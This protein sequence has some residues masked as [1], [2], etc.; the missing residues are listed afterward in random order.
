M[1]TAVKP[2]LTIKRR[3]KVAPEKVFAAW[4]DPQK[5]M[6]WMGPA[7]V[8]RC[9]ATNDLRVGGRYDIRMLADNEEHNV[10]GVYREIVPNEKVVFTWAWRS[11]PE[12]E[13]LVTVTIKPD[14]TGSLMTLLHEQFF[15]EDA[16]DRHNQGWTGTLLRLETFL[17]TDGM[18]KP[19]GKFVWNELN[20]RD[21]EGAKKFLG[22]ALG[23][24]FEASP[25]PTF[26][27]W[28]IKKGDERI[29]GI[30]DLNSDERCKGAPEHWL[31]YIAVDDVDARLTAALAAGAKEG[32]PAQD[33]PGVGRM[34]V[35]QQPGG[36][37]VAWLTPKPM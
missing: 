20:T 17:H 28:I 21:V 15:D 5:M 16:R 33:I 23:W 32:R 10:G 37:M 9:E 4:T 25:M 36:A 19:H 7:K 11:T 2:S 6:R 34:A 14:E 27:Y 35:L 31:T 8:T 1:D 26:T 24:T 22:A 29:A 12:R 30:F 13:S 18:E 3:F